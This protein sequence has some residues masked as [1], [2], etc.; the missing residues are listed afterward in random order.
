MDNLNLLHV[1]FRFQIE[2]AIRLQVQCESALTEPYVAHVIAEVVGT[3]ACTALFVGNSMVIRDLDMYA[4]GSVTST[5]DSIYTTD[6]LQQ[7]FHGIAVAGNRGASGIDGLL[8]A[9][10]GF[11][12][13]SEKRVRAVWFWPKSCLWLLAF[14][15]LPIIFFLNKISRS[16]GTKLLLQSD[17]LFNL[18]S[19]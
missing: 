19:S 8:S 6:F 14:D 4:K 10:I 5:G 12:I 3:G 16:L 18:V 9:A 11:S 1:I 7:G 2:T 13:G 17:S 15:L